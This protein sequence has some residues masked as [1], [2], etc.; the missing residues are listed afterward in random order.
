MIEFSNF[1][2]KSKSALNFMS[3]IRK[4]NSFELAK[5]YQNNQEQIIM[6]K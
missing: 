5:N 1:K 2:I 3:Q 6:Q 4:K